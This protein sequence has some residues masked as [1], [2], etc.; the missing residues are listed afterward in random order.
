VPP[1]RNLERKREDLLLTYSRYWYCNYDR[2]VS[3]RSASKLMLS[4][5]LNFEQYSVI[6]TTLAREV[7]NETL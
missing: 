5:L 4:Y 6:M 3:E 7:H 1:W 2:Y